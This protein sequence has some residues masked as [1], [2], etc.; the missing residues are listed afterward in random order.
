M[1]ENNDF[2]KA[3]EQLEK[4]NDKKYNILIKDM[5]KRARE[6]KMQRK[7]IGF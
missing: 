6:I 5:Q 2:L 1:I 7:L 3:I 4:E